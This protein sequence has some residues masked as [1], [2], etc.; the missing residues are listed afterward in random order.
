MRLE[1]VL[2]LTPAACS[3]A[4]GAPPVQH[5]GRARP[6]Q[7]EAGSVSGH[8]LAYLLLLRLEGSQVY[9]KG[10]ESTHQLHQVPSLSQLHV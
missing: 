3:K 5:F 8:R 9:R 7:L 1:T 6:D 2:V 10:E 4:G